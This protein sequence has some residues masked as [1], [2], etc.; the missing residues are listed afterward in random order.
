MARHVALIFDLDGTLIDS[1]DALIDPFV[2]LGMA[3]D[4][5]PFGHPIEEAC[6]EWGIDIDRY[7]EL[8]DTSVAGRSV[9]TSTQ[10]PAVK[11]WHVSAGRRSRPGSA[12]TSVVQP[13]GWLP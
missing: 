10:S 11:S 1:D 6:A 8:Y 7:I 5:I 3:R 2:R 9:R 4:E 13:S 12:P